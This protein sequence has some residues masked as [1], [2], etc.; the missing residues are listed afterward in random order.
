MPAPASVP[1][2]PIQLKGRVQLANTSR[3]S[4]A[5]SLSAALSPNNIHNAIST[6]QQEYTTGATSKGVALIVNVVNFVNDPDINRFGAQ[7]DTDQLTQVLQM[8]NFKVYQ[9]LDPTTQELQD[10][11]EQFR[12]R[13]FEDVDADADAFLVAVMSHGND[14][15]AIY[16]TDSLSVDIWSDIVTPFN[17]VN[18]P[19]LVGKPKIFILNYCRGGVQHD[20]G[21]D[22]NSEHDALPEHN[23]PRIPSWSDMLVCYS[24]VQCHYSYRHNE[25]TWFIQA[26]C[27]V[28]RQ[29]ADPYDIMDLLNVVS[30]VMKSLRSTYGGKQICPYYNIGFT[31]KFY[32]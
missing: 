10:T 18:C 12:L 2:Q 7:R 19:R 16:T 32:L 28:L 25:G 27:E 20:F 4:Q 24:T 3:V 8:R 5:Y 26:L 17:N 6:V 1:I 22:P 15:E 30:E 11:I 13:P 29:H 21:I 31:K 9:L 14:K 23:G